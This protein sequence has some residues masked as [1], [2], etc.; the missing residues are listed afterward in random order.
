MRQVLGPKRFVETIHRLVS[1]D[2]ISATA[3]GE[4]FLTRIFSLRPFILIGVLSICVIALIGFVGWLYMFADAGKRQAK[5]AAPVSV[6]IQTI[7]NSDFPVYLNGL[8]IVQPYDTVT[9]RSRVDGQ[10]IK[11]GFRQGQMVNESIC[12]CRLTRDRFRRRSKWRSLKRRRT[13]PI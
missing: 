10:V 9:V 8:G 11:V 4:R 13:R 12:W 6:S 3:I 2:N 1:K 7:Q 5:S